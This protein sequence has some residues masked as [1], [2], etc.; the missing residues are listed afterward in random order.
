MIQI[1]YRSSRLLTNSNLRQIL[2]LALAVFSIRFLIVDGLQSI[3][4]AYSFS[5][6]DIFSQLFYSYNLLFFMIFCNISLIRLINRMYDY[7]TT[8][9]LRTLLEIIGLITITLSGS[10]LTNIRRYYNHEIES[11]FESNSFIPLF[12]GFFMLNFLTIVTTDLIIYI[13]HRQK[14]SLAIEIEK[15]NRARD[16]YAKLKSQLNP[17]FLFNSLNVLDYLVHT[18]TER[19]SSYLKKLAG[20]YRYLLNKEEEDCVYLQEEVKFANSYFDLMKERFDKGLLLE[21]NIPADF[22]KKK[23]VPCGLQT[24]IENATKHNIVSPEAPLLIEVFIKDSYIVVRNNIQPKFSSHKDSCGVGLASLE[25]QYLTLCQE[26]I[27]IIKSDRAFEVR[28]P[29][30]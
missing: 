23:I 12:I 14:E 18:D 16:Q 19:A 8:P 21:M 24:L 1:K 13:R 11:I 28:L 26:S 15:K 10:W 9:L 2:L 5:Y 30:I 20:V 29:L 27:S 4:Q 6:S 3:Q 17:H 25:A 22:N 7:G